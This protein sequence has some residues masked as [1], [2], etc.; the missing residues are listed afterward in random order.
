METVRK[1][2]RV[3]GKEYPDQTRLTTPVTFRGQNMY[4]DD[5]KRQLA[6]WSNLQAEAAH[7]ETLE[8]ANDFELP[9]DPYYDDDQGFF[10]N[11][12]VYEM[13]EVQADH[14]AE[15][16]RQAEMEASAGPGGSEDSLEPSANEPSAEMEEDIPP[17]S[18]LDVAVDS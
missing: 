2:D 6:E 12:T 1:K 10:G 16:A 14:Q 7:V 11:L 9:P 15:M 13:R 4:P 18:S 17:S 5:V 8:E 3:P